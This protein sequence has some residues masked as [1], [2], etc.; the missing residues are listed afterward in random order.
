M[1]CARWHRLGERCQCGHLTVPARF[2]KDATH[3]QAEAAYLAFLEE[4]M[5][6]LHEK[7]NNQ[8]PQQLQGNI[9]VGKQYGGKRV[10]AGRPK[11]TR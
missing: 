8:V 7:L 11:A 2:Y 3:K 10:G 5:P 4:H 9:Q 6:R 1:T